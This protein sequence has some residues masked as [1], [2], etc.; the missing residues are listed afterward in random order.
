[1]GGPEDARPDAAV[2]GLGTVMRRGVVLVC[3]FALFPL[4]DAYVRGW[5]VGSANLP[6]SGVRAGPSVAWGAGDS[7]AV[8]M[9]G[10]SAVLQLP[11]RQLKRC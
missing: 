6:V 8:G 3:L 7:V 9:P 11:L 2:G 1:M 10:W 5:P 4:L